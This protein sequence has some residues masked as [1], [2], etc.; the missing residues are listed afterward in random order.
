MD[1]P[2]ADWIE[3]TTHDGRKSRL[4]ADNI[5]MVTRSSVGDTGV[6]HTSVGALI[7]VLN[8][9]HVL[10]RWRHRLLFVVSRRATNHH[11][12]L[13]HAF[14]DVEWADVIFDRR[15]GE[16]RQQQCQWMVDRRVGGRRTRPDVDERL[17][18]FGWAI[19]RV[20]RT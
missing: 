20:S 18:T 15:Q 13:K 19:V 14:A 7:R 8:V 9:T 1:E 2:A 4:R 10:K 17:R 11:R 16:R 6:I 5:G 12:Y 3:F